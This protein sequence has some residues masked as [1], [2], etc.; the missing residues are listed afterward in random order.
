[1]CFSQTGEAHRHITELFTEVL[2]SDFANRTM[3]CFKQRQRRGDKAECMQ[4]SRMEFFWGS[5]TF[6][7]KQQWAMALWIIGLLDLALGSL[8]SLGPTRQ[9]IPAKLNDTAVKRSTWT[10]KEKLPFIIHNSKQKHH[11]LLKSL[12]KA[13]KSKVAELHYYDIMP[14]LQHSAGTATYHCTL[15]RT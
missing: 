14:V 13:A 3:W 5:L 9:E 8:N 6:P 10:N 15:P 1:M 7:A 12:N 2:S 11:Y 4:T